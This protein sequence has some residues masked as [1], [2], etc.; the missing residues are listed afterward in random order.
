MRNIGHMTRMCVF[1]CTKN[2]YQEFLIRTKVFN[3][4]SSFIICLKWCYSL[5]VSD[6]HN[7]VKRIQV[8]RKLLLMWPLIVCKTQKNYRFGKET[9]LDTPLHICTFAT[10]TSHFSL[11]FYNSNV[12]R[13]FLYTNLTLP[14]FS[15]TTKQ[16]LFYPNIMSKILRIEPLWT[17]Y[18]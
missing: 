4:V 18:G 8:E 5:L 16:Y 7:Y 10:F 14:T 17:Y 6:L 9:Q 15:L 11:L 13:D 3:I 12:T 1:V 2:F